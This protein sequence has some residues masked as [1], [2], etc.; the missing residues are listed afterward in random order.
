M[1]VFELFACIG[2]GTKSDITHCRQKCPNTL[3]KMI[4]DTW[5]AVQFSMKVYIVL[6]LA[7]SHPGDPRDKLPATGRSDP[8]A[9]R[10]R[11]HG[12]RLLPGAAESQWRLRRVHP[13]FRQL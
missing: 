7:D 2:F 3:L 13:H 12:E 6:P 4:P 11:D 10:G 5:L 8:G 9:G 1:L